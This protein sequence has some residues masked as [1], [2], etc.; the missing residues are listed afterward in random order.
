M[1]MSSFI[2][3]ELYI[4][5]LTNQLFPPS[6]S[7]FYRPYLSILKFQHDKSPEDPSPSKK[8]P[9]PRIEPPNRQDPSPPF[10]HNQ[11][12]DPAPTSP[13]HAPHKQSPE[14]PLTVRNANYADDRPLPT[15]RKSVHLS[16]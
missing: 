2:A 10:L 15:L 5:V 8:H 11:H 12:R 9:S 1:K 4:T 3:H 13:T 7:Q 6:C 14:P 16:S